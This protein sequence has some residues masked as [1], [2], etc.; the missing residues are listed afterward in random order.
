MTLRASLL[1]TALLLGAGAAVILPTGCLACNDIGCNSGFTWSAS[2]ADET[3]LS[4][5]EYLLSITLDGGVYE[6]TC[7]VLADG[8]GQSSCTG[9]SAPADA[10]FSLDV[11]FIGGFEQPPTGFHLSAIAD[12]GDGGYGPETVEIAVSQTGVPLFTIAY[13][14]EYEVDDDYRGDPACGSCQLQ[15][16]RDYTW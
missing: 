13:A 16:E 11:G 9:P 14:L 2:S 1:L 8:E 12:D 10:P 4:A 6:V 5:G 15:E 3:P 7:T